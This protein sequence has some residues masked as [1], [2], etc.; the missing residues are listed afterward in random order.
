MHRVISKSKYLSGLQCLKY[1]WTLINPI[2]GI[3][4]DYME[5]KNGQEASLKF[6][7][8]A[9]L[10]KGTVSSKENTEKIKKDLLDYCGLDTEGMIYILR[11]LYKLAD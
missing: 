3:S 5:I 7:D 11:E 6:L 9:F 2:A 1:L 4:Y 8:I 10:N